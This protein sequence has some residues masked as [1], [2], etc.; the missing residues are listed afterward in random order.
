M[1]EQEKLRQQRVDLPGIA[2]RRSA[3]AEGKD[4]ARPRRFAAGELRPR[5]HK[6][7]KVIFFRI[8]PAAE[9]GDD[10]LVAPHQDQER[11]FPARAAVGRAVVR[12][13]KSFLL[14]QRIRNLHAFSSSSGALSAAISPGV[15]L[16]T[17]SQNWQRTSISFFSSRSDVRSSA[18][19]LASAP[20]TRSRLQ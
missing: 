2:F 6:I 7:A 18:E 5:L 16:Y 1:Q 19:R 12:H 20:S 13:G 15:K 4:D 14:K 9:N 8:F 3:G 10:K 11:I 17:A